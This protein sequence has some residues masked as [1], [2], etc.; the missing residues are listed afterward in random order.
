MVFFV[1]LKVF[2][3]ILLVF[4]KNSLELCINFDKKGDICSFFPKIYSIIPRFLIKENKNKG[5]F[6]F[7][8][9]YLTE[10]KNAIGS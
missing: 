8:W 9:F 2:K 4:G 7:R 3:A 1:H 10:F 6:K 5:F